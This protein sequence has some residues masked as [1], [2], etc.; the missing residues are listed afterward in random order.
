MFGRS[1]PCESKIGVNPKLL[2]FTST[3]YISEKCP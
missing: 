1:K 2:R 3:F